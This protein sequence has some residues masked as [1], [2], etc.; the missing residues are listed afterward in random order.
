MLNLNQWQQLVD[1]YQIGQLLSPPE[2]ITGGLLHK[3]YRLITSTGRFAAKLLNPD[4]LATSSWKKLWLQTEQIANLMANNGIPTVCALTSTQGVITTIED[5]N[6][7][8]F[9]WVEGITLNV[10]GLH[11][12]QAHCIGEILANMHQIPVPENTFASFTSAGYNEAHWQW[13]KNKAFQQQLSWAP[14]FTTNLP[15]LVQW[16]QRAVQAWQILGPERCIAHRDFDP[17]NVLWQN[18]VKPVIIDWEYAGVTNPGL[19]LLTVALNWSIN[20]IP[21]INKNLFL[22][23]LEGYQKI[24]G[25]LPPINEETIWAYFGYCLDWLEFNVQR[26]IHQPENTVVANQEIEK[27][28]RILAMVA[29]QTVNILKNNR[30]VYKNT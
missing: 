23:V 9:P 29:K 18:K 12:S 3:V 6:L 26:A 11:M 19:D 22:A 14:L 27:S 25:A 10:N 17:K 7:L 2:P 4:L 24:T 1:Q 13:L 8:L 16:S 28:L 15:N 20:R 5:K 21:Q 30:S